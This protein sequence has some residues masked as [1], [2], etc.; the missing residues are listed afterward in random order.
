[1]RIALSDFLG[2]SVS[3]KQFPIQYLG[4]TRNS[5]PATFNLKPVTQNSQLETLF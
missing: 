5:Q 1:M 3:K 2:E 4:M